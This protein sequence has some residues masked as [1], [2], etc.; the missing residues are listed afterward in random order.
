MY[1]TLVISSYVV[2]KQECTQSY[3]RRP[4]GVGL[5][6]AGYDVR[7]SRVDRLEVYPFTCCLSI[8]ITSGI[9]CRKLDLISIVPV[10]RVT[11]MNTKAWP[12]VHVPNPLERIWKNITKISPPVRLVGYGL[13]DLM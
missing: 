11:F 3:V 8:M 6:V 2:E 5:L 1:L 9:Y 13:F 4:Y 10:H 7:S 12:S